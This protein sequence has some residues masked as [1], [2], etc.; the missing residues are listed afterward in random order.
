V[1]NNSPIDGLSYPPF[2]GFQPEGLAF[3]R[4]LK[5]NNHRE[6]FKAHKELYEEEL[7]WPMRCLLAELNTQLRLLSSPLTADPQRGIF[8]IYRDIR[9]SK[10]KSPYKTHIGAILSR[11]GDRK[12]QGVIYIH[13]EPSHCFLGAGFW[14]PDAATLRALRKGI[15]YLFNESTRLNVCLADLKPMNIPL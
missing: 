3:L 4:Q 6:W 9:F 1:K 14:K 2:P 15:S 13:I 8:R 5:A 11:S 10:D 12:D 7:L